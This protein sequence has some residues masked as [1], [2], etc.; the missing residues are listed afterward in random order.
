M[1][2]NNLVRAGRRR[3]WGALGFIILAASSAA[4]AQVPA[5]AEAY[6]RRG[7]A[8]Q[9][10]GN[11]SGAL[12][13]FNRAL[14]LK[15]GLAPAYYYRGNLLYKLGQFDAAVS[16]YDRL[17]ELDPRNAAAYYNR[18]VARF[19]RG[20]WAGAVGDMTGAVSLDSGHARAYYVRGVAEHMRGNLD[21]A[22]ADFDRAVEINPR[23]AEAYNNRGRPG[24]PGA[25][26]RGRSPT[27]AKPSRLTPATSRLT[28]TAGPHS[29]CKAATGKRS[30]TSTAAPGSAGA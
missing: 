18:G 23:Y 15:P 26:W 6:L 21:A 29:C 9:S 12:A 7:L 19:A 3:L 27:S 30:G 16:D 20:D 8:R 24:S 11:V 5:S 22:V 17:V 10:R 14:E 25:T 2:L 4:Q 1:L 13:D 28:P